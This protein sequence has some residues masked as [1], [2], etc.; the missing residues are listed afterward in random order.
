MVARLH[1]VA[2]GN[3]HRDV[4]CGLARLATKPH[5]RPIQ[6]FLATAWAGCSR[7]GRIAVRTAWVGA[8][9][10]PIALAR[11]WVDAGAR[12]VGG[13]CRTTPAH[14]AALAAA[15]GVAAAG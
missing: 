8:G 9:G 11:E 13:C 2:Y 10:V 7:V 1:C 12:L 5:L 4:Q 14:I 6:R 3:L 15:V